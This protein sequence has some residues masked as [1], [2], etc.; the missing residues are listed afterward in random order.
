LQAPFFSHALCSTRP[1][2]DP[3]VGYRVAL[4]DDAGGAQ[5]LGELVYA[6]GGLG[7]T[8]TA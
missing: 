7:L 8:V 6:R 3:V 2:I 5:G 1:L 4:Q